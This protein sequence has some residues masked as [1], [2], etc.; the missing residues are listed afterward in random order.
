MFESSS[1][2]KYSLTYPL[3]KLVTEWWHYNDIMAY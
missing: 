2:L 3:E 1:D